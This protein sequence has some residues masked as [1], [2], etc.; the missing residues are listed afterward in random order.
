VID[1]C[2]FFILLAPVREVT[3]KVCPNRLVLM[4]LL[5]CGAYGL[6]AAAVSVIRVACEEMLYTC[7][8]FVCGGVYERERVKNSERLCESEKTRAHTHIKVQTHIH[9]RHSVKAPSL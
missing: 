8:H 1:D 5:I 3:L 6:S 9:R 2:S 7:A 4:S